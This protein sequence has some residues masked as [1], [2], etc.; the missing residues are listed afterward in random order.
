[1]KIRNIL[2]I[3]L[4]LTII[5]STACKSVDKSKKLRKGETIEKSN[6]DRLAIDGIFIDANKERLQ[7]NYQNALDL[8]TLVLNKDPE[9]SASLYEI[10]RIY[11]VQKKTTEALQY[12]KKAA[13]IDKENI[14]FQL[15]LADLYNN[16][17]QF[18]EATA[19]WTNIVKKNPDK[20]ESYYD[21]ANAYIYEKKLEEAIKIYDLI[22]KKIGITE[23]ISMQKQK[24]Y[25]TMDKFG[26]AVV[27]IEKLSAQ[28]PDDTRFYAML[29]EMHNKKKMYDKALIYYN[30]IL[31]KDPNDKFIHISLAGYY[32]EIGQKDKSYKE[33]K[34]G[35]ANPN[36]D[37]DTKIQILL[38]YYT[39]TEIY[40]ELKPQAF[41]LSQILVKTH[42]NDAKAY[43]I[44][45]DFLYRDKKYLEA[46]DAFR[47]VNTI[48]SSKYAIW[49]TLLVVES[50]LND[51]V[52]LVN[53]SKRA[54]EL[55]PEQPLLYLFSGI[56]NFQINKIEIAIKAL[57]IG[58]DL[59]V[60]N[61]K[62]SV[63][64]Y[65][66]L[67]DIY[68]K[69]KDYT[70]AFDAFNKLLKIDTDNVYV[71]N[72]YAYY[73]SLQAED[74]DR[75]EQMGRKLNDLAPNNSSYQDTYAWVFYKLGKYEEA[76]KWVSK[77]IDNGGSKNDIILEHY[78]DILYKLGD[79]ENAFQYW[80][81]AKLLGSGSEFLQKKIVDK[82]LYE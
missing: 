54:I 66:Y 43:S 47:K 16:N 1:M 28:F 79:R 7:G 23:E 29:A 74:L 24:L 27:E 15:L 3:S 51:T 38:S 60:D 62:L 68:Y 49:E 72:N 32:R 55:F 78:G 48:D 75:A 6:G 41:E 65:T 39:V 18:K 2:F 82:K 35:I 20:I 45:A 56:A 25:L 46:R 57:K 19:I 77:A 70:N 36:L 8:F 5:L 12:A 37:I 67:G 76:K 4:M 80:S 59:V 42:P 52:A 9:N 44:Y 71:L 73:L 10:A 22:E 17:Q 40:T 69:N 64:F 31:E 11:Q 63:Q 13:E 34:V 50:E 14:W 30:K 53:E 61:D 21:W 81:K 33:L 58:V 26:K